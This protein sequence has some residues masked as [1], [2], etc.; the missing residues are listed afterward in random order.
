MTVHEFDI[1]ILA[2]RGAEL[3]LKILH[4]VVR[5]R[6]DV[7]PEPGKVGHIQLHIHQNEDLA[8]SGI[9]TGTGVLVKG[10]N[11]VAFQASDTPRRGLVLY[12]L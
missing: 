11:R 6:P 7:T 9:S 1:Q 5:L 8:T 4:Q 3:V 2:L 12:H 10:R